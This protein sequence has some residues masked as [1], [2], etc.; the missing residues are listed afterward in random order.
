MVIVVCEPETQK[1]MLEIPFSC[2]LRVEHQFATAIKFRIKKGLCLFFLYFSLF[3]FVFFFI[4][5]CFLFIHV[6][7]KTEGVRSWVENELMEW[8]VSEPHHSS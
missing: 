1:Q 3:M 4:H 7:F 5:V 2:I 6:C 8:I